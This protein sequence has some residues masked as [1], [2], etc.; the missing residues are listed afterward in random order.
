MK[1]LALR[2]DTGP[3]VPETLRCDRVRL[4]Q[5][6]NNLLHNAIKFTDRGT[7]VLEVRPEGDGIRLAVSDTGPGIPADKRALIFERFTQ[8]DDSLVRNHQGTGLGLALA[9]DL[10]RVMGG[11]L[12]LESRDGPGATFA[13][14]LPAVA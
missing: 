5:V 13:L 2:L 7:V 3:G 9:R 8:A 6:L 10:A 14:H 1:G 4:M 11:R 12:W